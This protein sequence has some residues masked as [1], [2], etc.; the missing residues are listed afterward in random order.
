MRIFAEMLKLS[1][2]LHELALLGLNDSDSLVQRCAAEALGKHPDL[3]NLRPLLDLVQRVPA[4]DTHLVY[5]ARKALRDQLI[6]ENSFQQLAALEP[7][8]S[9]TKTIADVAISVKSSTAAAFLLRQLPTLQKQPT[10]RPSVADILK[11]AARYAPAAELG[12]L[13]DFAR[14]QL[15]SSYGIELFREL[16]RQFALFKSVDE[17]LQQRGAALPASVREWGTNLVWRFFGSLD[18]YHSWSAAPLEENPTALPWD[19]EQR[20]CADGRKRE[21]TSSL[22]HGEQLTGVLRSSPFEL[23]ERLSFWLCGHNGFPDQPDHKKNVVRLRDAK[24]RAVIA[25]TF[26]PRNDTATR[27]TWDLRTHRGQRGFV[28]GVDGDAGGAYA[29]LAFGGFEPEISQLRPSEFPPRK[30]TDWLVSA[31]DLAG[32]LQVKELAPVFR[33]LAVPPAGVIVDESSD[34]EI[35]VA[36]ARAW[37]AL[38]P[39]AAPPKLAE[40]LTAA[41]CPPLLRERLGLALAEVNSA[42]AKTAVAQAMKTVP[43]RVQQRWAVALTA[44]RD[45]AE[46][47]LKAIEQGVAGPRL[48]QAAGTKNRLQ[49]A[50]PPD[51]QNRFTRLTKDLTAPNEQLEQLVEQRRKSYDPAKA[52]PAEGAA[53]FTK[54]CGVCHSISGQGGNVGPQ[55]D[56]IGIRGLER[57][58]EDVLDPNRNVDRAF[59]TTLLTLKDGDVASGL[60]RREEGELVVL[61]DSTGKEISVAKSNIAE[62]RESETSLMPENFGDILSPDDFNHLMAF[63]LSKGADSAKR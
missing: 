35:F 7:G 18:T 62:R 10:A 51:W 44:S 60:F 55:L 5:V 20:R 61:A 42:E 22:P 38:E 32:R 17:G 24:T 12:R 19:A 31:C 53:V 56:G 63:L 47:F 14:G 43:F 6:L 36:G 27:V 40:R 21:L 23:P 33:R 45:G 3:A 26:P 50:N 15:P 9:D 46:A 57:L 52:R 37:A 58:C 48:L 29:W 2:P 16:E 39:D 11:H 25:E 28:E 30:M 34:P 13:A 59:R 4:P 54:N 41:D 8:E 1:P 49:A